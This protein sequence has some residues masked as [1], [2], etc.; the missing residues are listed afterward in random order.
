MIEHAVDDD[1]HPLG[2]TGLHKMLEHQVR[3]LQILLARGADPIAL[4]VAVVR[5]A[6]RQQCAGIPRH[7][8]HMRIHMAV[9]LGI[10]LM[11][12]GRHKEGIEVNHPHAKVIE[13]VQ[14]LLHALQVAA[15]ET[16]HVEGLG[17][18]VPVRDIFCISA[19]VDVFMILNIVVGIS[20]PETIDEDLVHDGALDPVRHMIAGNQSE[21]QRRVIAIGHAETIV[22]HPD[23]VRAL[24]P[25]DVAQGH[26]PQL[27]CG[28]EVIKV[29][30]AS[31]RCHFLCFL[32]LR[33]FNVDPGC[34]LPHGAEAQRNQVPRLRF[35]R[36]SV[37][38]ISRTVQ[39]IPVHFLTPNLLYIFS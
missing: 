22:A 11:V 2:M 21:G 7:D 27:H 33:K 18:C 37:E 1:P 25:E 32:Q 29:A 24:C 14:L 12:G 4:C 20:V 13:I 3:S 16:V 38:S 15:V 10:V 26:V 8:A 19:E 5:V 23:A 28:F 30:V 34:I 9:I 36:T 35:L 39:C 6:V 17:R 31:G